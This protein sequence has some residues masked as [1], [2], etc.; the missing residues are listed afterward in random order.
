MRRPEFVCMC[1]VMA[2]RIRHL[3]N[4]DYLVLG[5]SISSVL[6]AVSL[7]ASILG[8]SDD[9]LETFRQNLNSTARTRLWHCGTSRHRQDSEDQPHMRRSPRTGSSFIL[10]TNNHSQSMYLC[11][12]SFQFE[13]QIDASRREAF[14]QMLNITML[15]NSTEVFDAIRTKASASPC[16]VVLDLPPCTLG[17]APLE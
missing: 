1:E 5:K 12:S 11:L 2:P 6:W 7:Y 8:A 14:P 9:A 15:I 13:I 3:P 10:Y 4:T 16:F 17:R